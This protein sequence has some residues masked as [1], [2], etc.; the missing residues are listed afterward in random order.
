[1]SVACPCRQNLETD[2]GEGEGKFDSR[3]ES[4]GR[5]DRESYSDA[6]NA[7]VS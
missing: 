2:S 1:M 6:K 5:V 3:E 4:S 7:K